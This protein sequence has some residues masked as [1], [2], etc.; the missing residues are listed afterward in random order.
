MFKKMR[1]MLEKMRTVLE[2]N[3]DRVEKTLS[4]GSAFGLGV[5]E[6][7]PEKGPRKK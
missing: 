2:K 4:Y 3:A 6:I 7:F 1:T 5:F